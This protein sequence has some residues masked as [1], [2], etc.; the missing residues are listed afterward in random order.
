M[1][2]RAQWQPREACAQLLQRHELRPAATAQFGV[3]PVDALP[4]AGI[5]GVPLP[6]PLRRHHHLHAGAAHGRHPCLCIVGDAVL[7]RRQRREQGKP[8]SV[9]PEPTADRLPVTRRDLEHAAVQH[10]AIDM[11]QRVAQQRDRVLHRR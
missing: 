1:H 2:G 11:A 9:R 8:H 6:L 7:Q 3:H 4:E 5:G 10:H